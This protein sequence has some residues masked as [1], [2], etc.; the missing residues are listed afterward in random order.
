MGGVVVF[1]AVVT[2]VDAG[3]VAGLGVAAGAAAWLPEPAAVPEADVVVVAGVAAGRVVIGVGS[4]G[5]GLDMTLAI[6]SV[7]PTSESL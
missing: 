6:I 2:V 7:S 4:S 1:G 3:V 5:K